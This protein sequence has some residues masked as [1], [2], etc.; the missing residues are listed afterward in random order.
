MYLAVIGDVPASSDH[1]L[2][3]SQPTYDSRCYCVWF[4]RSFG[5]GSVSEEAIRARAAEGIECIVGGCPLMFCDRVDVGHRYMRWWLQR[6][7]R[8]PT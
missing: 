7:G 1:E 2:P 3:F 4:H 8:V 6:R 5:K